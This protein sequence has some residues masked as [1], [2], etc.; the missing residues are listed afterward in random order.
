MQLPISSNEYMKQRT[1]KTKSCPLQPNKSNI[2]HALEHIAK[3]SKKLH[4]FNQNN[5][6]YLSKFRLYSS[7]LFHRNHG[8]RRHKF[9]STNRD[10][11]NFKNYKTYIHSLLIPSS[12]AKSQLSLHFKFQQSKG[13]SD[14]IKLLICPGFRTE[15]DP[16]QWILKKKWK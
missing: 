16:L 10:K 4:K 14:A 9:D 3:T 8:Y 1:T 2:L 6:Y 13:Q 15:S 12:H 5:I 11:T 7:D